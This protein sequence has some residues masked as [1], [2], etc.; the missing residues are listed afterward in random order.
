MTK[1]ASPLLKELNIHIY[2]IL[3]WQLGSVNAVMY[4]G[5][6]EAAFWHLG[7][8]LADSLHILYSNM[9]CGF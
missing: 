1:S 5:L 4:L 6:L 8:T 9:T 2:L 7:P 3:A